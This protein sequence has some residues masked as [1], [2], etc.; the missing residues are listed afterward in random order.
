VLLVRANAGLYAVQRLVEDSLEKLSRASVL[1]RDL[2]GVALPENGV[3]GA[4]AVTFSS[5]LLACG[6]AQLF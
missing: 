4:R 1:Q 3:H 5:Y 2:F 6:L